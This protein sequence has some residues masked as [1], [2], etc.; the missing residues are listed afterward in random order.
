MAMELRGKLAVHELGT[1]PKERDEGVMAVPKGRVCVPEIGVQLHGSTRFTAAP[2][3][4]HNSIVGDELPVRHGGKDL[5]SVRREPQARVPHEHGVVGVD[6]GA[7][8]FGEQPAGVGGAAEEEVQRQEAV[9]QLSGA[10]DEALEAREADVEEEASSQGGEGR[11]GW[12]EQEEAREG[13]EERERRAQAGASEGGQEG[14]GGGGV[15][16]RYA[17]VE[18]AEEAG[19]LPWRGRRRRPAWGGHQEGSWPTGLVGMEKPKPAELGTGG[20]TTAASALV[21]EQYRDP[22]QKGNGCGRLVR[23]ARSGFFPSCFGFVATS[24]ECSCVVTP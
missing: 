12:A 22:I 11:R 6:A 18:R 2:E 1:G 10:G 4:K 7:G 14:D 5:G 21:Q 24:Y 13:G 9:S 19:V 15:A 16:A 8:H 17:V 23:F 3:R 20:R